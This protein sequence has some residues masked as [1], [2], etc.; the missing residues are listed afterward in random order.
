[1]A[2]QVKLR[3]GTAN[4]HLTFTGA[5]G[6]VTV[7][8]T[9]D[10]LRVHDGSLA[11]GHRL[12]KFSDLSTS[13]ANLLSVNSNI[14]PSSNNTYNL[15]TPSLRWNDIYLAGN[16]IYLNDKVISSS[17]NTITFSGSPVRLITD[18]IQLGNSSTNLVLKV[19]GNGNLTQVNAT[20]NA[21]QQVSFSNVSIVSLILQNVLGTQ[22]GGTGLSSF[23]TNGVLFGA[24][25]S[26][27]AFASGTSG[28]L[29]QIDGS[30]T[31][32]FD[33]LDGGTF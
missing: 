30:G 13:S 32:V 15:G 8:T 6:E 11:G 25:S 14:V 18:S 7:D 26:S 24:N 28:E 22:Y 1:M 19:G 12:A 9:N 29:L 31:P 23:T 16:S 27:L 20:T 21:E 3:R 17:G 4:Q 10:T 2:I 5:I 33:K